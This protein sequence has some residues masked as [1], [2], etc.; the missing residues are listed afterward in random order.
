MVPPG[1]RVGDASRSL[2]SQTR[3]TGGVSLPKVKGMLQRCSV[4]DSRFHNCITQKSRQFGAKWSLGESCFHA[5]FCG[6]VHDDRQPLATPRLTALPC[7]AAPTHN[8]TSRWTKSAA[9][10]LGVEPGL[11]PLRSAALSFIS[12]SSVGMA[13]HNMMT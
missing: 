1:N 11:E 10:D 8:F 7:Y 2:A 12:Y 9:C 4:S 5:A 6:S 13:V 3:S